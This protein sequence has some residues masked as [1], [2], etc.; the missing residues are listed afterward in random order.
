[1]LAHLILNF[2]FIASINSFS[3]SHLIHLNSLPITP[4]PT[5]HFCS[6]SDWCL[7]APTLLHST[8]IQSHPDLNSLIFA[9]IGT[10]FP[11]FIHPQPCDLHPLALCLTIPTVMH[12]L[13]LF[14]FIP[15]HSSQHY[16]HSCTHI[17]IHL[18]WFTLGSLY[19]P[20]TLPCIT[21]T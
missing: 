21:P 4:I 1:M 5:Y 6:A 9:N 13:L 20:G 19:I 12:L 7:V 11:H 16:L 14:T 17:S 2:M 18:G 8:P 10:H 3:T 15:S